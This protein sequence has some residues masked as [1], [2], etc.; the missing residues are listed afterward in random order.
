MEFLEISIVVSYLGPRLESDIR[1]QFPLMLALLMVNLILLVLSYPLEEE[2][3]LA[4]ILHT[5]DHVGLRKSS[6]SIKPTTWNANYV[7][8]SKETVGNCL[9][10]IG[11]VVD[12][13]NISILYKSFVTKFSQEQE[14][15]SYHEA[16]KD[17]RWIEVL[18]SAIQGLEE[19]HT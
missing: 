17:S 3:A 6:R 7:L 14:P 1:C 11:D 13:Y 15:K 4:A 10:F 8:P 9:Y 2:H 16:V 12:Y 19:N 5:K 18:K